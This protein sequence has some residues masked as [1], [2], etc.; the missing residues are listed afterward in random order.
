MCNIDPAKLNHTFSK[1]A[2]DF[3]IFGP[4]NL[5]NAALLEKAIQDHLTNPRVQRITG[6]YR[7][8]IAVTHYLDPTTDLWVAVDMANNFVAG[9]KLSAAQKA[10]LL[11]S[12]N[13]Q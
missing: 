9:W 2:A 12:G 10:Y 5:A 4:W 8:T 3:G 11:S 1:H 7:G 6:T 13:V